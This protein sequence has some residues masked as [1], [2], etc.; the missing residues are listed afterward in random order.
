MA[1]AVVSGLALTACSGDRGDSASS[2]PSAP[3]AGSGDARSLTGICPDPVVVQTSWWPESTH[4]G[5]YQLLGAQ[6]TADNGKKT[7]RGPLVSGGVDTGVQL[8]IRAG[9]PARGQQPVAALMKAD[10]SITLGQQATEEQVLGWAQGIPTTAVIAPFYVDPVVFIWDRKLHPDFNSI[11]DIGQT[12]A[13][14][15]TF[16][17]ANA[18]YLLG[19]G[20]L[21]PSQVDY[22][23]DGSPS[24]FMTK[25]DSVVG[26]FATNEPF[27]YR[28]LGRDVDYAYV[29]D[30]GY[31]DYRNA[32]TIRRD[33]Q[34][35]LAPCLRKLVPMM[36]RGMIDF[37]SKPGPVLTRIVTLNTDYKASFPYPMAQAEYGV[38]TMKD[39]GLVQDPKSGGFGSFDSS[40]VSRMVDILRPIYAGKKV[41]VPADLSADSLVTNEY[42]DPS[43]RMAS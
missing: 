28:S 24:L 29:S 42:L 11:Q 22:S 38:T 35:K 15:Y 33:Q 5:I 23:Y 16:H 40:R 19:S 9:G 36:Q 12:D 10:P 43:I 27:I 18:D 37:M 25:R 26:G 8:E 17:S 6:A 32:W 3:A 4:G 39:D 31:P 13:T 20:I 21:R 2:A 7:I 1:A 30:T 41:T 14:V 34:D